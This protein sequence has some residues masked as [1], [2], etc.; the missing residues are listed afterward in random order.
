MKYLI[1]GLGNIGQEYSETRHNIGFKVLD[2]LAEASNTVFKDGRRAMV[3]EIKHRGRILVLI[4]PTTYM[5]LS[6]KALHYWIQ[7]E[8]ISIGNLLVVTDDLALPFGKIRIRAKGSDAGHNGLKSIN[9]LLETDQ[10][11]RLRFGIGNEFS[12]GQQVD[13]V[14]GTWDDEELKLLPERIKMC[15]EAILAFPTLGIQ[16]TMNFYNNK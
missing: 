11:A 16:R 12:K 2:A 9:E 3:A 15:T 13:Y 5:N 1:A 6:G 14:L 8:K 4:K 10:Y 7:K